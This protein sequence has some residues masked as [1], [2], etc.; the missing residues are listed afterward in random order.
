MRGIASA[1]VTPGS[2]TCVVVGALDDVE[3]LDLRAYRFVS[4]WAPR[5]ANVSPRVAVAPGALTHEASDD[6]D[7]IRAGEALDRFIDKDPLHLPSLFVS[8]A[9]ANDPAFL[10]LLDEVVAQFENAGRIRATRQANGF[11]WQRQLLA[12]LEAYARRR[13]PD[14]WAGALQGVPALIC[15]AG[16][17]LDASAGK[18]AELAAGGIVFA[19]DSAL[20]VLGERSVRVDFALSIDAHKTPE[21]C[22]RSGVA[23]P[24]RIVLSSVSPPAWRE[25]LPEERQI[26]L[27]SRQLTEDWLATLGVAKTRVLAVENCGIAALELAAFLGCSPI[28]LF[29]LEHAGDSKDP[30][31]WHGGGVAGDLHEHIGFSA[32][33]IYPKVPGNFQPEIATPLFR[34]WR[35]LDALCAGYPAG[36]VVNVIDRGARLRNTTV[37]EPDT[38]KVAVDAA[39]KA[40]ALRGLDEIPVATGACGDVAVRVLE[41][42]ERGAP[43]LVQARA[44]LRSGD[45]RRAVGSLVAAYSDTA[46]GMVMGNYC[47]KVMPHLLRPDFGNVALW[48]GLVEETDQLVTA[49]RGR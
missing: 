15:G 20:K 24:D 14:S 12:N 40:E 4:W 13:V 17:S 48:G 11:L 18:L 1:Q 39:K 45:V 46:F 33:K 16:P 2:R 9:A 5:G 6:L 38:L 10:P 21:K 23:R 49:A 32:T 36:L 22:L 44:A 30:T 25:A 47:L 43:H 34:E 29:G 35:V 8:A 42:V 19:A 26:F 27:S 37:V 41:A 3:G 31:K 7:R 28:Y